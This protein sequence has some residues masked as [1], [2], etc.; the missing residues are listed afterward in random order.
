M[1]KLFLASHFAQVSQLLPTFAQGNFVGKKVAFIPSA[2]SYQMSEEERA[3]L[4]EFNKSDQTAL[5]ELGFTVEKLE[6]LTT[7]REEIKSRLEQADSIFVCGGNTFF[8]LQALRNTGALEW[9]KTHIESGKLYIGSSAG[10]L[11]TQKDLL[12]DEVDDPQLAPDLKGDYT[13]L[14]YLDFYLYVHYGG[15]YWGNDDQFIERYYTNVDYR[16]LTDQQVVMM[17]GNHIKIS[18]L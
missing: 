7:A 6:L 17:Q 13:A 2:G 9:I 1:K 14:G 12:S 11:I 10:S 16:T 18:D 5:E 15:H 3:G 4:D 8:L